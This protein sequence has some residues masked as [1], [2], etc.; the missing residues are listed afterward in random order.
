MSVNL[1]NSAVATGLENVSFHYNLKEGQCQV[2]TTIHLCSFHMLVRLCSK[3]FKLGFSRSW[4][5]NFQMCKLGFKE[6]EECLSVLPE[7]CPFPVEAYL[8][9]YIYHSFPFWIVLLYR[10]LSIKS[11]VYLLDFNLYNWCWEGL[12]A[13]GEGDDRG[14]DGW[15][16]S[17]TRWMR[18][19]VNSGSWW[20]TGR[21]GVLWFM[22]SQR[23]GHDWATDL[24]WRDTFD[25]LSP[26]KAYISG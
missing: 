2:L 19:W 13:G 21:P 4:P 12:G 26:G 16:A 14:W 10:S 11:I 5:E 6:V 9:F 24:I 3:S 7:P 8:E 18:V 1:E 23:V 17:L 15:M 22:G 20:W 25:S